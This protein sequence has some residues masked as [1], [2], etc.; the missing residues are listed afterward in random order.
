MLYDLYSAF[1]EFIYTFQNANNKL[2]ILKTV[3]NLYY[4]NVLSL[5]MTSTIQKGV[6]Q[7]KVDAIRSQLKCHI[8][9]RVI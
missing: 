1:R 7:V 8:T 9:K 4:E 2:Y 5:N 3:A 6:T